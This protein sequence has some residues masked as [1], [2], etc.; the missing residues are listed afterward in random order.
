[1]ES[2]WHKIISFNGSQ[3]NAFEEMVCQ[4]AIAEKD[5]RC[6]HFERVGTPDGGVECY[7][8]LSN[9][10][11]WGWQAKFYDRLESREWSG[12][13]QSLFDAV[14]TH[15][16]LVKYFISIPHNLS[17]GRRGKKHRKIH[18]KN[19]K[20]IGSMNLKQKEEI[21]SWYYGTVPPCSAN[22]P[23]LN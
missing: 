11:E 7:W 10:T 5:N 15:P 14:E 21:L 16:Q 13:K 12:I 8:Q 17:D 9:G 22:F 20:R 23:K 4:I 1:M 18:G 3:A 19:I 2:E 6:V